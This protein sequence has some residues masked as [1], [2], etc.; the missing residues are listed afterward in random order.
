MAA[1]VTFKMLT[2]VECLQADMLIYVVE[3]NM[4]LSASP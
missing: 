1:K 3:R 2:A 4:A